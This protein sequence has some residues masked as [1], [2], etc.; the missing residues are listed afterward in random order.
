VSDHLVGLP[1]H[2]T[3]S[4]IET[5]KFQAGPLLAAR[6]WVNKVNAILS[7][8]SNFPVHLGEDAIS[9]KA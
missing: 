9:L 8:D 1:S 3:I 4:F 5:I 2:G 6:E 7:S